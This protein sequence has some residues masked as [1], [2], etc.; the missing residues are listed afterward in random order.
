MT[1]DEIVKLAREADREWDC[2]RDMVEW[3]ECFAALVAAA[4][5]EILANWMRQHGFST[6]Q[7]YTT[8][9]LLDR[10]GTEMVEN[11]DAA[12]LAEREACAKLCDEV[13]DG[14]E[15][16]SAKCAAAIRARG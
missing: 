1:Q 7:A 13:D 2:D 4:E 10:L 15:D 5:R 3:L 6:G 11:V 9:S 14:R 16:L 8:D 12:V